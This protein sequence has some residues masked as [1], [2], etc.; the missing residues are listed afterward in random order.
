[1]KAPGII[2]N[3]SINQTSAYLLAKLVTL[4][5]PAYTILLNP[6]MTGGTTKYRRYN[7]PLDVQYTVC[8]IYNGPLDRQYSVCTV[9]AILD[10]CFTELVFC[11]LSYFPFGCIIF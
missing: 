4:H 9:E 5:K 1:M 6:T 2:K 10:N 7:G 3:E 11:G 8:T